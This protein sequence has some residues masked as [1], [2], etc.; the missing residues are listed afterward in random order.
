MDPTCDIRHIL[1]LARSAWCH[2]H[3]STSR[4]QLVWTAQNMI[5]LTNRGNLARSVLVYPSV[6]ALNLAK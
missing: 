1:V 4:P 6:D 5:G 3:K 2:T